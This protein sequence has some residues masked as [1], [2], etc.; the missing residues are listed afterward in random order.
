MSKEFLV[1]KAKKGDDQAFYELMMAHK[2]QL[3]RIAFSY[4]KNDTDSLEAIQEV[5]F[6]AFKQIKKLKKTSYF[7]TWL[8]RILI[9][10][11][12]DELKRKQKVVVE[13]QEQKT[14]QE[15]ESRIAIETAVSQLKPHFQHVIHLRYFQDLTIPEIALILEKPEGT[16]KTWLHKALLEMKTM[17]NK[18]D[19]YV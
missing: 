14:E 4:L 17:M 16:I 9:N 3:Y 1:K 18:E 12:I 11:C 13:L 10:Y 15:P 7:S 6:R 2:E 5:T 8:I 19:Y